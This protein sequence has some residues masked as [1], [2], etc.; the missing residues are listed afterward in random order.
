MILL[1]LKEIKTEI[2]I[3]QKAASVSHHVDQQIYLIKHH[4]ALSVKAK[5]TK[6]KISRLMTM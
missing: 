6:Y 5:T 2:N 1:T 3:P 4:I